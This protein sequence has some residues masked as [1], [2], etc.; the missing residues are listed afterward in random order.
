MW[1]ADAQQAFTQ[2]KH[3]LTH[4]PVLALPDLSPSAAP[5]ELVSD[6]SAF[7]VGS[8][9]FQ[10]G[11]PSAYESRKTTPAERKYGVGEQELLA[12]IHALT[13]WRCCLQ[14]HKVVVV[15]VLR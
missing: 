5:F 8:V 12:V 11:K 9:L 3:G 14:H 7:A 4:A 13:V 6:A 10:N 1:D 15:V 2:I